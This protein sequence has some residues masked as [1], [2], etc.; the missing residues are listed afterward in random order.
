MKSRMHSTIGRDMIDR[1]SH[2]L[3]RGLCLHWFG[4]T[5]GL[6]RSGTMGGRPIT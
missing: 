3:W 1:D 5:L 4:V 2:P 6:D